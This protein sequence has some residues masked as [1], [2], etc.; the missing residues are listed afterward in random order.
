MPPV[1]LRLAY[2][3]E[4]L[5]ALI[6]ALMLWSQVGGQTHL[7]LMP[8]YDKLSLSVALALVTVLGTMAAAAHERAWNARTF[9]FLL[10]A[11]LIMG[12]MAALTYYYH[13]HE[14]DD[15]GGGDANVA[16]VSVKAPLPYG[17]GSVSGDD[18]PLLLV[19][20]QFRLQAGGPRA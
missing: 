3:S 1:F 9:A 12:A 14:D 2:V 8:W 11:L 18:R 15:E 6:A 19:A 17:R 13:V 5:L 20:A 7:D 16:S 10:M 4:F